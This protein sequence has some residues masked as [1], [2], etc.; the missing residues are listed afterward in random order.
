[1]GPTLLALGP[2]GSPM[3]LSLLCALAILYRLHTHSYV[4]ELLLLMHTS[5]SASAGIQSSL[6]P[7]RFSSSTPSKN[8]FPFSELA[9][10]YFSLAL[11]VGA[12]L[13]Q[14]LG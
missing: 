8:L 4:R 1:M 10:F 9:K 6:R 2:G 3:P 5:V 14:K 13:S 11:L 12:L 7:P